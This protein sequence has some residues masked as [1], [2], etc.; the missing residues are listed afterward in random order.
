VKDHRHTPHVLVIDD[1]EDLCVLLEM[2]LEHHGY[3]V[4]TEVSAR[5]ALALLEREVFDVVILDLRLE[6]GD[7]MDVLQKIRALDPDL[8]VVML[9]AHGSIEAAV[10]AMRYGAYG[11]LTKPFHDHELLQR[12]EHALEGSLLRRELASFRRMLGG[13]NRGARLIGGSDSIDA[14]RQLLSRVAPADATVL[15]TGESGTGKELAARIIHELSPRSERAFVAI[16]CA[17]LPP[18]LLESELFGHV[19]GAFTGAERN[20]TGLLAAAEGGTIF[21][22]EVGDAPLSVQAKLLRVLQERRFMPLGSVTEQD[23]D[24][25]VVAATNRDL[26]QAVSAGTFREDLYYRLHVVPVRMPPLRDRPEDIPP[27]ADL[28]LRQAAQQQGMGRVQL[29]SDA[30]RVLRNHPWP[31]NVRELANVMTGA[32]LIARDGRVGPE[33]L[34]AVLPEHASQLPPRAST[35]PPSGPAEPPVS[36]FEG[37]DGLLTMREAREVCDRA[38]LR[39]VLR[40]CKGNVSRAARLAERN[41]TDFHDLLRRHDIDASRFRE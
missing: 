8:P 19:R 30:V 37:G 27:L 16:N 17:A 2:R 25:R 3:A 23:C 18:N 1:E 41:R 26:S 33:E 31:G 11:F 29:D 9:T 14:V 35:P 34:A 32:A 21:L 10:E 4:T 20:K 24:V 15:I 5:G 12:L 40:R 22:D 7:G 6:D 28:F 38:Y 36:M 13:P 39:E